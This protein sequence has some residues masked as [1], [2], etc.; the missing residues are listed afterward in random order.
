MKKNILEKY[1]NYIKIMQQNARLEKLKNQRA[2][3]GILDESR[4]FHYKSDIL[5]SLL[6]NIQKEENIPFDSFTAF[7]DFSF[8]EKTLI[9]FPLN[10]RF[11][12]IELLLKKYIQALKEINEKN[13]IFAFSILDLSDVLAKDFNE[14]KKKIG[15]QEYLS[16]KE[17]LALLESIFSKQYFKFAEAKRYLIHLGFNEHFAHFFLKYLQEKYQ[18]KVPVMQ[19]IVNYYFTNNTSFIYQATQ[20]EKMRILLEEAYFS[21]ENIDIPVQEGSKEFHFEILNLL[22]GNYGENFIGYYEN[23]YKI[24]ETATKK[25]QEIFSFLRKVLLNDLCYLELKKKKEDSYKIYEEVKRT[26]EK[27]FSSPL[28][29]INQKELLEA[30]TKISFPEEIKEEFLNYLL[31]SYQ[32]RTKQTPTNTPVY[33]KED[34]KENLQK[35]VTKDPFLEQD[36]K[37]QERRQILYSLLTKEEKEIYNQ[38][39]EYLTSENTAIKGY[40]KELE[41]CK[42]SLNEIAGFIQEKT[43]EKQIALAL[44][45]ME[46]EKIKEI[47]SQINILIPYEL[48]RKK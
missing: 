40:C 11:Q 32:E 27:N 5:L 21:K 39:L 38:A 9:A 7:L 13:F 30:L 45:E 12:I 46:I 34:K 20:N 26:F 43:E 41:E 10:E 3:P 29:Q 36:L 19:D 18:K 4:I 48:K 15:A 31:A 2:N 8:I 25:K 47:F 33:K 42:T 17:N 23:I 24:L 35:E 6:L 37:E 16:Q 14:E 28:D 22:E 1:T 44:I